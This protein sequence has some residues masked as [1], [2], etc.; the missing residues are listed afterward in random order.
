M[1]KRGIGGEMSMSKGWSFQT[2]GWKLLVL[3]WLLLRKANAGDLFLS[4]DPCIDRSKVEIHAVVHGTNDDPFW[5]NSLRTMQQTAKDMGFSDSFYMELFEEEDFSSTV[6]ASKIRSLINYDG[7]KQIDGLIVSIPDEIVQE[8]VDDAIQ[9]GIHVWGVTLGTDVIMELGML[10]F[11]G[12]DEYNAGRRA[13]AEFEKR[14]LD[15]FGPAKRAI[16]INH[17]PD[18]PALELRF[19]GFNDSLSKAGVA[20]DHLYVNPDDFYTTVLN[21]QNS[22][23]NCGYDFVLLAG[24]ETVPAVSA[25]S[26]LNACG[27]YF[28]EVALEIS[29]GT[30]I[31]LTTP[32]ESQR[33]PM[34]I[35]AFDETAEVLDAISAGVI[36]F[37]MTQQNYLQSA[38]PVIMSALFATTGKQIVPP[39][40]VVSAYLS[41]PRVVDLVNYPSDTFL[42]CEA[43]AFPVCEPGSLHNA[44]ENGCPCI[45][46]SRIRIAAVVHGVIGDAFWDDVFEGAKQASL[47]MNVDFEMERFAAQSDEV[48]HQKMASKIELIC[49]SGVNGLIVSMPSSIVAE[50]V[51]F[52]KQLRIPVI[53]VNS[54]LHFAKELDVLHVGQLE[55]EAGA[56][57]AERMALANVVKGYCLVPEPDNISLLQ[58]CEGFKEGLELENRTYAGMVVVP[59]DRHSQ[60]TSIVEVTVGDY[61]GN[62]DGIGLLITGE[63]EPALALQQR[64][65][66]VALGIF[67]VTRSLFGP[68]DDG[69][70]LF[71]IDQ[72]QYLQGSMPVYLLTYAAYTQQ[73]LLN[74]ALET[75][76]VVVVKSPSEAAQRCED[77]RYEVCTQVPEE[78]YNF[79]PDYMIIIGYAAVGLVCLSSLVSLLWMHRYK[80]KNVVR[81]SQPL[82][83]GLIVLGVTVSILAIIPLSAQTEYRYLKDPY[84]GKLTDIP[85]PAIP[86]VDAAC[87]LVPWLY[88][89]GFVLTFSAL[90]AKIQRIKMIYAAGASM[91]RKKVEVKDVLLIMIVMLALE[92][93][94]LLCW[95]LISPSMWERSALT[96]VDGYVLESSGFCMSEHG[97]TFSMVQTSFHAACL[98]CAV[99]L[100]WQTSEI[101][102]EFAEGSY[103]SL[104]ILCVFQTALITI[105]LRWMVHDVPDVSFFVEAAA[106]FLSSYTVL[107]LI[108]LPKMWRV[109]TGNDQLPIPRVTGSKHAAR[110]T[111]TNS[112]DNR[113]QPTGLAPRATETRNCQ[114][115]EQRLEQASCSSK[116]PQPA[117]INAKLADFV[118]EPLLLDDNEGPHTLSYDDAMGADD[119]IG[120]VA[121]TSAVALSHLKAR[122]DAECGSWSSSDELL[123]EPESGQASVEEE[124]A[125]L[126]QEITRAAQSRLIAFA[127]AGENAPEMVTTSSK[128]TVPSTTDE[129]NAGVVDAE[130]VIPV[131][132]SS[133]NGD[134]SHNTP[135]VAVACGSPVPSFNR[136]DSPDVGNGVSSTNR[137]D[138]AKG[139]TAAA[140]LV[141]GM[142]CDN[143]DPNG[144][145]KATPLADKPFHNPQEAS[146]GS[147]DECRQGDQESLAR[148]QQIME[149]GSVSTTAS[150]A[151][152][153]RAAIFRKTPLPGSTES[154]APSSTPIRLKKD[155]REY[156]ENAALALGITKARGSFLRKVAASFGS[157]SMHSSPKPNATMASKSNNLESH[158]ENSPQT[159]ML[160]P[161]LQPFNQS[162]T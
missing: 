44:D 55:H 103:I 161:V 130:S 129:N 99:V 131:S 69:R 19:Q 149:S 1:L 111:P 18:D 100:C 89:I 153:S 93:T 34:M 32:F 61:S 114:Q 139:G 150:T 70:V 74:D 71:A 68:L 26:E 50:A 97:M 159:V 107:L 16:F 98:L 31:N 154:T 25:A 80:D 59:R 101:P 145:A 60:Y 86:L 29:N 75:G 40:G 56:K 134:H 160:A 42:A 62:W 151:A 79:L 66:A 5:Q 132:V 136:H 90:C 33:R 109:S 54:G 27:D 123:L 120:A 106:L 95:T 2:F 116:T 92:V 30:A 137:D 6:M 152:A 125:S 10:G 12:Q 37:T 142:A 143:A 57:A 76:P 3:P 112:S 17:D 8:A 88:G 64:H 77:L 121:V 65:P 146:G 117:S 41:G 94:I 53:N 13:S 144:S 127:S 43:E 14:R 122:L 49:G 96:E 47:D 24:Q 4:C 7:D 108:F 20:V 141:N 83:L 162:P 48:L 157:S 118:A 126:A 15:F 52:C 84:T 155:P 45:D 128:P 133:T 87:M 140:L 138:D 46:R 72:Q 78:D 51:R 21:M 119:G 11:V 81:A 113:T 148:T 102:T 82:F 38:L 23:E 91:R 36:A 28:D 63:V 39:V 67:D 9:A 124:L 85:N 104:S 35:G 135:A 147:R 110:S 22:M 73:A 58:R 115:P 156:G 105:P 158:N